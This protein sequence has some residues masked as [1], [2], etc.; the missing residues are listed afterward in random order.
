MGRDRSGSFL[1]FFL[2]TGQSGNGTETEAERMA[3]FNQRPDLTN[4][5]FVVVSGQASFRVETQ[6]A[7]IQGVRIGDDG[8]R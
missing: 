6:K 8:S 3:A 2:K 7:D 5:R 1:K 4:D